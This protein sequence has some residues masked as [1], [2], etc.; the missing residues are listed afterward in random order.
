LKIRGTSCKFFY[1][2]AEEETDFF[3]NE[4]CPPEHTKSLPEV[5]LLNIHKSSSFHCFLWRHILYTS[6]NKVQVRWKASHIY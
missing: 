3:C 5:H 1:G 6:R 2:G 4:I